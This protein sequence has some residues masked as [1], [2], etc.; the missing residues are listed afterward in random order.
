MMRNVRITVLRTTVN[1][2]LV[3]EYGVEG[4]G[5]CTAMP[6]GKTFVTQI[7]KP[8]GFCDDAWTAIRQYVFS[9]SHGDGETMF[10][11]DD[12]IRVPGVA[13][14]SCN[15]GLRPVIFKIEAMAD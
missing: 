2:D 4:I 6:A 13:I 10:Y 1:K 12:W 14:S 11:D 8:E 5:E 3:D 9:L 15:D 7:N